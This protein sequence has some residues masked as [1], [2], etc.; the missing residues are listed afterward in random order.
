MTYTEQANITEDYGRAVENLRS[1]HGSFTPP[2]MAL[3]RISTACSLDTP[4]SE[5]LDHEDR[6]TVALLMEHLG[7]LLAIYDRHH[8]HRHLTDEEVEATRRTINQ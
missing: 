8:P 5:V 6:Q 4:L 7:S 1:I 2:L 3:V